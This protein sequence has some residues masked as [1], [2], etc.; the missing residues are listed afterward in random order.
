V[1]V[2][3]GVGVQENCTANAQM[4]ILLPTNKNQ[5]KENIS[6]VV[7]SSLVHQ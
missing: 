6:D 1:I 4:C 5:T 7:V 3:G 2:K